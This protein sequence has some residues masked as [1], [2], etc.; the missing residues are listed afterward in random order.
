MPSIP[1]LHANDPVSRLI[2]RSTRHHGRFPIPLIATSYDI[3][4]AGGLAC[5]TA[6]RTFRNQ[7]AQSIEATLTF[8]VPV[9]AVLYALEARIGGRTVKAVA[10]DKS[11]ARE[12]Y[13][14]A[15]DC[16]KTAVLHEELL[17]GIHMLSVAHVAPGTEIEVTMRFALTLA[18]AGRRAVLRIPTTVGDVYGVSGLSDC[19]D[20]VLGGPVT[21]ANLKVTSEAGTSALIDGAPIVGS[22]RVSLDR[23]ISIEVRDWAARDICGRT[24]AG[25]PFTLRIA[26][27]PAEDASLDVA[28]LIDHS[29]SMNTMCTTGARLSKHAA[30]MLG[31]SE[32]G[33]GF[34]DADRVNL[35]Q[36]DDEAEDLGIA[37]GRHVAGLIRMLA[38]PRGG[39]EIGRAI[40]AL[41]AQRPARDVVL[42]TDGMSHALDVQ[43]LAATGTRFS[44]VLIGDDSLEANV[45]H[46]AALTGGEILVA[47]GADVGVAL[48]G[49]LNSVRGAE[50]VEH[51]DGTRLASSRRSGMAILATRGS[52]AIHAAHGESTGAEEPETVRA[53]SAYVASLRL[54]GLTAADAAKLAV[55]EGLVG[56]LTSLVLVDE[57]GAAQVGLPAMRKVELPAPATYAAVRMGFG[58]VVSASPSR[59]HAGQR[60]YSVAMDPGGPRPAARSAAP[61]DDIRESEP[62]SPAARSRSVFCFKKSNVGSAARSASPAPVPTVEK[63]GGSSSDPSDEASKAPR[64]TQMPRRIDWR[65][66]GQRLVEGNMIGLP[67]D[68]ADAID[69][70]A[71]VGVVKRTAKRLGVSARVLVIGLLARAASGKDRHAE[72]VYRAILVKARTRDI[73]HAAER[74]GLTIAEVR[75]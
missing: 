12:T 18:W 35:W 9:H 31:L 54:A 27:M 22:L 44:V 21:A 70:A 49:V 5:V 8:P 46:L 20:L 50:K 41:L 75:G 28:I 59:S 7:E 69:A 43:T 15:V 14:D 48:E 32:A 56:H 34:R 71:R 68:V 3:T 39:T 33:R 60:S 29:G 58:G 26:P 74:L 64:L 37:H 47:E 23:P 67:H 16:G 38:P 51:A 11:A 65:S 45:G 6:R 72:R 30:V 25:E 13:E 63:S 66:E 1:T 57:E 62:A 17:R 24:A 10:K 53:A 2:D 36:F 4:L 52:A 40:D 73:A 55:A 19:D 42:V 61:R